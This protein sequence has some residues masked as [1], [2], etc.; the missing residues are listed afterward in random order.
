VSQIVFI[1]NIHT[2]AGHRDLAATVS[3][4]CDRLWLVV[5]PVG[6][7][8]GHCQERFHRWSDGS[9]TGLQMRCEAG[10]LTI[11]VVDFDV[12]IHQCGEDDPLARAIDGAIQQITNEVGAPA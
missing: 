2:S 3:C 12:A 6:V 11:R 7:D 1:R 4:G 9:L 8:C 5:D 10:V